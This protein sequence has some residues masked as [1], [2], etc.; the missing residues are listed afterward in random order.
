MC[1]GLFLNVRFMFEDAVRRNPKTCRATDK[2]VAEATKLWLKHAKDRLGARVA[3]QKNP[4][5]DH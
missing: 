5:G 4:T 2:E 1:N 3:R